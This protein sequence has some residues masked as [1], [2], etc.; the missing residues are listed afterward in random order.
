MTNNDAF[1]WYNV[2]GWA[3]FGLA[4]PNWSDDVQSQN[5]TIRNLVEVLGRNLQGIMWHTDARLSTPPSIN[6]VTRVHKLCTRARSILASRSVSSGTLNMEPAHALPAPEVFKVYP[7]PYFKVRNQW[8]K[9]YC[10]LGL[11]SLTEAMQHQENAR[12]LEISD[13]FAGLIGQYIHRIYRLMAV[14]LLRVPMSEAV[15]PEFTLTEEQLRAYNPGAWFTS[16][17]MI[18]T[19][20]S[21]IQWPTEDTLESI[22]QGIPV[23]HLP[24]LGPWPSGAG[25]HASAGTSSSPPSESFAPAP[26]A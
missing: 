20:P 5:D 15:K 13:T 17:E 21:L 3:D 6:T 24:A 12:P 22:T 25:A 9:Q 23:S 8:L 26:G 14:E 16:T 19:V 18:D 1:L 11:L 7:T 2:G 10:S 4:V